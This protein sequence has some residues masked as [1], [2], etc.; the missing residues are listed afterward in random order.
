[1]NVYHS[2][3]CSWKENVYNASVYSGNVELQQWVEDNLM[4]GKN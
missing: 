1:M 3:G 2:A 4:A